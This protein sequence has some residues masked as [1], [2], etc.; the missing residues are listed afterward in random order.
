MGAFAHYD[1]MYAAR[2]MRRYKHAASMKRHFVWSA[3]LLFA[4]LVCVCVLQYIHSTCVVLPGWGTMPFV[5]EVRVYV[6]VYIW[7]DVMC[8]G[9]MFHQSTPSL[10][11][12]HTHTHT[13]ALR[14]IGCSVSE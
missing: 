1:N 3:V 11:L 6:Y 14:R 8:V 13:H 10:S 12:S 5:T 4:S 2:L 9:A 7:R